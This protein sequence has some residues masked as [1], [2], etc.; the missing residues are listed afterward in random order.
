M[1]VDLARDVRYATRALA[2]VSSS[3]TYSVSYQ[4]FEAL[5]DGNGARVD[6]MIALRCE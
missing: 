6:P 3:R 1:I 2:V 4:L 5:R